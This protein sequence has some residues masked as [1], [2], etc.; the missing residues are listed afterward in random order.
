MTNFEKG[1]DTSEVGTYIG[2]LGMAFKPLVSEQ[3]GE[4]LLESLPWCNKWVKGNK[5][6][7]VPRDVLFCQVYD[8]GIMVLCKDYKGYLHEG[9]NQ[10]IHLYEALN[11]WVGLGTG[12]CYLQVKADRKG[13]ITVGID[14]D[15]VNHR[16]VKSEGRF[17]QIPKKSEATKDMGISSNPL[18][19]GGG[20]RTD[21]EKTGA[22]TKSR[23]NSP[24]EGSTSA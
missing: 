21:A 13:K 6:Y 16:W 2:T 15:R 17:T 23:R 5:D 8:S 20:V 12:T 7:D 3:T 1:G 22:T 19:A 18:L 24:S 11:V 9:S 14:E 4:E 10:Y